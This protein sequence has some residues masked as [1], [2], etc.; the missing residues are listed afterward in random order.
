MAKSNSNSAA[1]RI[2]RKL[3]KDRDDRGLTFSRFTIFS[4]EKTI[5]RHNVIFDNFESLQYFDEL[6]KIE[7]FRK[8]LFFYGD[9]NFPQ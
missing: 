1:S 2:I 6:G 3:V 8:E 4:I 7:L 9:L 5:I